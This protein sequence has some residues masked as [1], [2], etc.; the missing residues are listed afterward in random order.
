MSEKRF[1]LVFTGVDGGPCPKCGNSGLLLADRGVYGRQRTLVHTAA[2]GL[3]ECTV[4]MSAGSV[5]VDPMEGV[6]TFEPRET[7][8]ISECKVHP[9]PKES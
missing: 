7:D 8:S 1:D 4:Q 2:D 9:T 3:R 6:W 5:S